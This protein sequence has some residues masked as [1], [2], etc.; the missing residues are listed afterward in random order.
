[1]FSTL[2]STRTF[3]E[4]MNRRIFTSLAATAAVAASILISSGA[5]EAAPDAT[6]SLSATN[7]TAQSGAVTPNSALKDPIHIDETQFK[8]VATLRGVGKQV[9]DCTNGGYPDASR[10]PEAGLFTLRGIPVG[11]HGKQTGPF[12]ANFDGS[13]V[14]GSAPQPLDSPDPPKNIP[15]LKLTG[16]PLAGT[17]G[18]FSNVVFIQRID[19]RG[20]VAP[21]ESCV[22]PKSVAVDYTANYVFWAHN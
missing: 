18:V 3:G 13:H 4:V 14:D 6:P 9:Y 20:G 7:S 21:K 11:I 8:I 19:T 22:A 10:E 17:T 5:A 12:W 2:P 16:K 1:M 15:W